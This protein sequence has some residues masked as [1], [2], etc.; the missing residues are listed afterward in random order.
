MKNRYKP[1]IVAALATAL[2]LGGCATRAPSGEPGADGPAPWPE[3]ARGDDPGRGGDGGSLANA[4]GSGLASWYGQAFHGRRTASGEPFDMHALTAAH[5][6]LPFGTQVRVRH[7][8]TGREVVVRI[9]DRGP[10]A[11]GRV[12]DLSHAAAR[13]LGIE[14]QGVARVQLFAMD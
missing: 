11:K 8:A 12:I 7:A 2:W 9:N 13:V 1:A 5:R 4:I 6:T 3:A 14:R 10:F